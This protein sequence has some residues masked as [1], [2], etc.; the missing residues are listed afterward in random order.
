MGH[1]NLSGMFKNIVQTI[2]LGLLRE[3]QFI[4]ALIKVRPARAVCTEMNACNWRRWSN[5]KIHFVFAWFPNSN[6]HEGAVKEAHQDA[7]SVS[8]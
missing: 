4:N 5:N 1:V 3:T 8:E 2:L 6:L 7:K